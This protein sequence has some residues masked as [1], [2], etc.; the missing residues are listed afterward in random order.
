MHSIF[1]WQKINFQTSQF[2]HFAF[3]RKSMTSSGHD[4]VKVFFFT[5]PT[6]PIWVWV[7]RIP[8]FFLYYC[9]QKFYNHFCKAWGFMLQNQGNMPWWPITG[10]GHVQNCPIPVLRMS[11][12]TYEL[13]ERCGA[14]VVQ[15]HMQ[16][17]NWQWHGQEI[18]SELVRCPLCHAGQESAYGL[19]HH[20]QEAHMYSPRYAAKL[21][22]ETIM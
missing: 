14:A 7:Q 19:E 12:A 2:N 13:C 9:K 17:H 5:C 4:V 1:K 11:G 16:S 18:L 15:G 22:R 21:T 10:S 6:D 20:L 8:S 3:C